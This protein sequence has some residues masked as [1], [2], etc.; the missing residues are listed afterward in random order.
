MAY[1]DIQSIVQS[2]DLVDVVERY[3]VRL[4][5]NGRGY[6]GQCPFT[7]SHTGRNKQNFSVFQAKDK[8]IYNC[9]G[10]GRSGDV[11]GF[12]REMEGFDSNLNAASFLDTG[13]EFSRVERQVIEIP[14][15]V[16]NPLPLT[17]AEA[18]HKNLNNYPHAVEWW[19]TQGLKI[20]T[21]RLFKV[22]YC[23]SHGVWNGDTQ[24]Y[25]Y[26]ETYTIPVYINGELKT[27]RHR[28]ANPIEKNNKYRP[29][30]SGDGAWLYHQ[31]II[32]DNKSQKDEILVVAGEKKVQ[33]CHQEINTGTAIG[34]IIPIVSATAGATNWFRDYGKLWAKMMLDYKYVFI[35]FDP[36]EL[37]QAERTAQLFGRRGLVI[38]FPENPDDLLIN[39]PDNGLETFMNCMAAARPIR[40][41]SYWT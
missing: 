13:S 35:G 31:D 22:G 19:K 14:K 4:K 27:I 11:V 1:V 12:V 23:P 36:N 2:H 24:E 16:N 25:D 29:E 3:G 34:S 7:A 37:E 8:W 6:I 26:Y 18:Y 17:K 40:S 32:F 15:R 33:V 9:F 10:C 21:M 20:E 5:R 30:R 41:V 28:L 39:N 38:P